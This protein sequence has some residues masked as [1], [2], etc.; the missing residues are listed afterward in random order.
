MFYIYDFQ[1]KDRTRFH[2]LQGVEFQGRFLTLKPGVDV[3]EIQLLPLDALLC[4]KYD[5]F[6]LDGDEENVLIAIAGDANTYYSFNP[7]TSTFSPSVEPDYCNVAEVRTRLQFW[8]G[9]ISF[10]IKITRNTD[11]TASRLLGFKLGCHISSDPLSYLLERGLPLLLAKPVPLEREVVLSGNSLPLPQG[12]SP[13]RVSEINLFAIP[14]RTLLQ[15][16]LSGNTVT[17]PGVTTPQQVGI[18]MFKYI[19]EIESISGQAIFQ[20]TSVP[21]I[22]LNREEDVSILQVQSEDQVT[23]HDG[24]RTLYAEHRR[25]VRIALEVIAVTKKDLRAISNKILAVIRQGY[26][27]LPAFARNVG[28]RPI[29]SPKEGLQSTIKSSEGSRLSTAITLEI[30]LLEDGTDD[31]QS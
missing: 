26:I 6:D 27:H 4:Y 2:L 24:L 5:G 17:F 8:N 9:K 29:G 15:G 28:V 21:V 7:S 22:L 18:L 23:T 13:D 30:I 20:I 11:G 12:F 25:N 19:P 10:R 1:F 14:Q 3:G 16:N 31:I